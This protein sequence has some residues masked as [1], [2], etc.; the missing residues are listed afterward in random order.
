M[1]R[2]RW[3]L[4]KL[5]PTDLRHWVATQCRKA[6]LSI[7]ASALLMGHDAASGGA[8]RDWYDAPRLEDL[9]DEQYAKLPRGPLGAVKPPEVEIQSDLPPK[10]RE[11]MAAFLRGELGELELAQALAQVRR[12]EQVKGLPSDL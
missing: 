6:G 12:A 3:D 11:L 7:V 9:L 4:P 2:K 1:L 5:R 10:A 8:M